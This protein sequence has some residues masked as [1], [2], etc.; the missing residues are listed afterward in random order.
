MAFDAVVNA[1]SFGAPTLAARTEGYPAERV[2]RLRLARGNYFGC[3]GKPA[4]SRLIYP[5]PRIDG[6]LGIHLTLDLAGRTRFGPDV[7]WVDGFDYRVD[8][9]RAEAFYGAIR[10]YWPGLP[11]GALY[12]DYAG[13][14]PKLTGPGEAA[15]DFRIDGPAEHGLPG[16]VHLFGIESPGLTSSLSLAE[17]VADR[18]DA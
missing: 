4:F 11:D 3:T 13:L 16:I 17:A 8:P 10:R 7:E 2:P 9:R 6:G 14:R 15:A 5:A 12:P 1:A 18:L